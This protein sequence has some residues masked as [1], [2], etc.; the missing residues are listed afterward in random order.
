MDTRNSEEWL[1]SPLLPRLEDVTESQWEALRGGRFF[2]G[3]QSV[4]ENVLTGVQELLAQHPHIGLDVLETAD[5]SRMTEPALYHAKIGRNGEPATKLSE[6]ATVASA[7]VAGSGTAMLKYCYV[8]VTRQTDPV[9]LFESYSEAMDSLRESNPG[10]RILH[11]TLPLQK[12]WGTIH[13]LYV[14]LKGDRTTHRELNWIRHRYNERL[15]RSY[16]GKEPIFDIAR[17]QSIGR[18][19]RERTVRFRGQRVPVLA[20]EWTYDGGHLNEA[21]RRRVGEAFLVMLATL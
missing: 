5:P 18:D 9:Q 7:G 13:H 8:D 6:F 14:A 1:A 21:A 15:R 12:D 2:F 19:G 10:L 11:I 16:D 4:G 3:H 17:L 20:D